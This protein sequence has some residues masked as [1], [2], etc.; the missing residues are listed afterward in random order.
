L[1]K[2]CHTDEIGL[3]KDGDLE[4]VSYSGK[5]ASFFKL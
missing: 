2:K 1:S 3:I 4:L 5:L